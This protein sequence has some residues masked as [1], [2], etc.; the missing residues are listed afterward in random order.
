V[1]SIK[2][3]KNMLFFHHSNIN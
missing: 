3:T 2:H 1:Q